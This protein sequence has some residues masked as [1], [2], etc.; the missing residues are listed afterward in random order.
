[1]KLK[2]FEFRR[3]A[4]HFDIDFQIG[5]NLVSLQVRYN[6]R[7]FFGE[8]LPFGRLFFG[9]PDE[10]KFEAGL[11]N[12]AGFARLQCRNKF[13]N[14]TA[15]GVLWKRSR[16]NRI[17]VCR[18]PAQSCYWQATLISLKVFCKQIIRPIQAG[19]ASLCFVHA[20]NPAP[21]ADASKAGVLEP[22]GKAC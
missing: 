6:L 18:A 21:S 20:A 8:I 13:T 14:V 4:Q 19:T 15:G 5:L 10:M 16:I 22:Y 7:F 1:M 3:P 11:Y 17:S 12:V 9:H 2:G